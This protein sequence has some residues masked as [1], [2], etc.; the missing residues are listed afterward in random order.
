MEIIRSRATARLTAQL[1]RNLLAYATVAS[2]AGIGVAVP[3]A[4]AKVVYTATHQVI[5][6]QGHLALDL[7]QDGIVD[8]TI[9]HRSTCTMENFCM[10]ALYAAGP[11]MGT[12]KGNS[13]EG[14]IQLFFQAYALKQGS[15]INRS[16]PFRGFNMYYRFRTVN[17]Y[18]RLS[19]SW[20]DVKHR[21]LGL[22]FLING[23]THFGWA[24]LNVHVNRTLQKIGVLTGYAYE[25]EANTPI[26]AGDQGTGGSL[27]RLALGAARKQ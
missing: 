6:R 21:Y 10:T 13:V 14:D 1:E 15:P 27:G 3:A 23:Q 12:H 9:N 20:T 22:K 24:R 16:K 8:F 4:E 11:H 25:T 19:G 18:G 2:A 26:I 17:S 5:H 7:N